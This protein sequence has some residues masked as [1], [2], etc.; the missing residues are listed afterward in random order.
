MIETTT[1]KSN[2][3]MYWIHPSFCYL[4]LLLTMYVISLIYANGVHPHGFWFRVN[5]QYIQI[6]AAEWSV[7][8]MK[9]R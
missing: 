9:P 3:D 5:I 2:H 1:K 6:A 7:I 4:E 8:E